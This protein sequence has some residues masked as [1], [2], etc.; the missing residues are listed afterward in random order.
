MGDAKPHWPSP[1]ATIKDGDVLRVLKLPGFA[2]PAGLPA[3]PSGKERV[4]VDLVV[5]NLRSG[6]G[7]ELQARQQ[8]RLVGPDGT[9]Y[10]P[11]GDS[12]RAP[13]RL[14]GAAVVPAGGSR[15]FTLVYDVPPGQALQL[16]Y[17]GFDVKSELV[18]V[19]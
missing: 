10:E 3:P 16:E 11:A 8:F 12:G 15:R 2:V 13:C 19:R 17:R 14:T 7:I 1:D 5:E 4:G 9:R 6:S 18:K